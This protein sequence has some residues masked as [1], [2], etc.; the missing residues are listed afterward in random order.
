[1]IISSNLSAKEFYDKYAERI[2][3]RLFTQLVSMQFI[4][5][6]VRQLRRQREVERRKNQG[7]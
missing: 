3:S 7:K 1:M 5:R 6:D 2:V 4:G